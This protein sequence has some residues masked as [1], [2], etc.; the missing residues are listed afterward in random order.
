MAGFFIF[1]IKYEFLI[2]NFTVY[3][4]SGVQI[5]SVSVSLSYSILFYFLVFLFLGLVFFVLQGKLYFRFGI[6]YT[7]K[8]SRC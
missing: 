1:A 3:N 6:D 4:K 8:V 7:V 5:V 2:N